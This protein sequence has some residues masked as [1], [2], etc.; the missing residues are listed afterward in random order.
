[1]KRL[2]AGCVGEDWNVDRSEID[3][4]ARDRS[5]NDRDR[6]PARQERQVGSHAAPPDAD[7]AWRAA[8]DQPERDEPDR[9]GAGDAV[10]IRT[11]VALGDALGLR[12]RFELAR[13]W[14]EG[15]ADAGHLAIQELMLGLARSTGANGSFEL[16][17]R[18]N[19]PSWSIDV[20]VR[21]DPRRWL[22]VEECWN[23]IG[24]VGEGGRSFDRKVAAARDLAVAIGGDGRTRSAASGSSGPRS[25]TESWS[26]GTRR[27]S[28][29]DSRGRRRSGSRR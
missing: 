29:G 28:P 9:G 8:R 12:S 10:P 26:R 18:P 21:D 11:W 4:P 22:I 17:I 1:M 2:R 19:D 20:F 7:R 23:T 3:R 13:D 14:Q 16:P 27:S 5:R 25:G 15:P 6:R 24:N